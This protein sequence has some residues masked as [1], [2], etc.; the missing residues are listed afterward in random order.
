M[1]QKKEKMTGTII[2]QRSGILK[3]QN[4]QTRQFLKRNLSRAGKK[5]QRRTSSTLAQLESVARPWH[6]NSGF[7][8]VCATSRAEDDLTP[9]PVQTDVKIGGRMGEGSDT[10]SVDARLRDPLNRI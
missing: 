7:R 3:P 8:F 1:H 2:C 5:R 9:H 10:D 6:L 4:P